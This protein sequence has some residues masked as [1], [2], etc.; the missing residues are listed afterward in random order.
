ML[1]SDSDYLKLQVALLGLWIAA[2]S[3]KELTEADLTPPP[4][5][6]GI[7]QLGLE[8]HGKFGGGKNL[9]LAKKLA[10][11]NKLTLEEIDA[12]QD[13]FRNGE[14]DKSASGWGNN[15]APSADWICYVLMGRDPGDRWS[16][17]VQ[18]AAGREPKQE[19]RL[20]DPNRY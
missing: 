17:D 6:S 18:S 10:K 12:M 19:E 8:L 20:I 1:L 16:K 5:V 13:F 2:A 14:R 15:N 9:K 7:A 4:R 11:G 3:S